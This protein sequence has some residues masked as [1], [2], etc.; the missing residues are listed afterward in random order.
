[1]RNLPVAVADHL[2][3][4]RTIMT[5]IL[6][7]LGGKDRTSGALEHIGLWT[8]V[9]HQQIAIEGQART[10]YGAG[11]LIGMEPV[12]QRAGLEVRQHRVSVSPLA[13]EVVEALRV[14]DPRLAPVEIH[15]WHFSPGTQAPLADPIRIFKG[16][17]IAAPITTP[18]EGGEATCEI[19]VVSA[20]WA[21]TRSLTLKRSHAALTARNPGDGFRRY[22]DI[23][24]AVDTAWGER[25][26][27]PVP[28]FQGVALMKGFR[29][30][31][32]QDSGR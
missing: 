26:G 20:A 12:T 14:Y 6:I 19:T 31:Q 4:R 1:M 22:G 2:A 15:E 21:L 16:N 13:P 23:S 30:L 29:G 11:G 28:V 8:G 32:K 27:K 5:E 3:A 10:Y 24:G 17:I 25:I 18:A 7:W 9:D